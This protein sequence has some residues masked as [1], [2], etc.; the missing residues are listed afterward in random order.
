M[1]ADENINFTK[2]WITWKRYIRFALNFSEGF[3]E[4]LSRNQDTQKLHFSKFNKTADENMNSMKELN[5]VKTVCPI[6]TKFGTNNF[7][8]TI[9]YYIG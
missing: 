6:S 5:N 1:A 8:A 2:R 3:I 7:V 9:Y 4:T